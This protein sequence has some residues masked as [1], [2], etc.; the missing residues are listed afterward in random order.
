[1]IEKH[2]IWQDG[3]YEGNEGHPRFRLALRHAPAT[4]AGGMGQA[5]KRGT[6]MTAVPPAPTFARTERGFA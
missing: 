5:E 1:M 6:P 3:S 2:L 4:G